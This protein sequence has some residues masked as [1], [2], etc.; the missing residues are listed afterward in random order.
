MRQL[1]ALLLFLLLL[2]NS[3]VFL[4]V[5][6]CPPSSI[7]SVEIVKSEKGGTDLVKGEKEGQ[8]YFHL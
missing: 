4:C 5:C 8:Y 7:R 3:S 6:V 2:V 1:D